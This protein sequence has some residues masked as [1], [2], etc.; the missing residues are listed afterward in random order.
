MNVL[1]V[2]TGHTETF[3]RNPASP[4]IVSLGDV[5]RTTP[6]LHL[7]K[8]DQ[9]TWYTSSEAKPL[10]EN[11]YFILNLVTDF[12]E[13][14]NSYSLIIN[15]ERTTE[16]KNILKKCAFNELFGF[17]LNN[18]LITATG[19][20][21]YQQGLELLHEK[22]T[23]WSEKLYS[24]FAKTW[25]NENYILFPRPQDEHGRKYCYDVGL[26][27]KVGPKWPNKS[28]PLKHWEEL[29]DR[30][31]ADYLVSWQQGYNSLPD[32]ISWIHSCQALLTHDSLGLHI[33]L[34]LNKKMVALFGPT[35]HAEIPFHDS[36]VLSWAE[37][38]ASAFSS[39]YQPFSHS[40]IHGVGSLDVNFV[41]IQLRN[42]LREA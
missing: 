37:E 5:L 17:D 32:Y 16:A 3:D 22:A 25:Q 27:W 21:N 12:A 29:H 10:L 23:N 36:T 34:A 39:C 24:L 2:K 15:L 35:R 42:C 28:W 33:G 26:N 14:S 11:N 13:L 7:F 20:Y 1:I 19:T 4:G 8:Y 38:P 18:K 30:V 40:K 9:V 6:L 41:E 31:K